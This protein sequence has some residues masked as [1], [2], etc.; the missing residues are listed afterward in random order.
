[1]GPWGYEYVC[2]GV[3]VGGGGGEDLLLLLYCCFTSMVNI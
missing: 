1:M 2:D 3:V